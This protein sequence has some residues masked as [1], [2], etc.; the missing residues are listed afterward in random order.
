MLEEWI[1]EWKADAGNRPWLKLFRGKHLLVVLV[2]LGILALLWPITSTEPAK[3][4]VSD[5]Y[6]SEAGDSTLKRQTTA[7]LEGILTQISG[8]GKVQVSITL[9]SDGSKS[10]ATNTRQEKRTIEEKDAKGALKT[11]VEENTS[12]DLSVSSGNPLLLE[13]KGPEVIGVLVVADGARDA[14]VRE[15]LAQATATLLDVPLYKVRVMPREG[16][17]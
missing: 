6:Q 12:N 7:A 15:K 3:Q 5:A 9:A 8:A 1:R 13:S 4:A 17:I 16:G 2:C 14:A 11:T 10:Y